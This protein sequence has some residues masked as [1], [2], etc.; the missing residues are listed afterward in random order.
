MKYLPLF[1]LLVAVPASA[2]QMKPIL[3]T[4]MAEMTSTMAKW[5]GQIMMDQTRITD[6]ED[7]LVAVTKERDDLKSKSMVPDDQKK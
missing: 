7:R 3:D 2:Q 6:L 1:L 4:D 5:R